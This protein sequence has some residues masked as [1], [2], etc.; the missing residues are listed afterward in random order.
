MI[1]IKKLQISII[2][3]IAASLTVTY[4]KKD[5]TSSQAKSYSDTVKAVNEAIYSTMQQN[6]FWYDSIPVVNPD[7]DINPQT[8]IN[9][10]VNKRDRWSF[11]LTREQYQSDFVTGVY[12]GYGFSYG[13]DPQYNMRIAYVFSSS[14]LY[15]AGVK[16]GWIIKSVNGVNADTSTA[17]TL[18]GGNIDGLKDTFVFVKPGGNDTTLAFAKK[19]VVQNTVLAYDTLHVD[20]E[21]VGYISFLEFELDADSALKSAIAYFLQ[22]NVSDL[23]LDLRYNGGGSLDIAQNLANM[24]AG[25]I[26]NGKTFVNLAFNSKNTGSNVTYKFSSVPVSLTLNRLFVITTSNTASASEV[27]INCLRPYMNVYLIGSATN[28]KPVGEVQFLLPYY[29]YFYPITFA[30]TNA[31][32]YGGYFGGL[33]VNQ[34]APDD[35][36][37]NFGDRNEAC[38]SQALYFITNG[39]F[40]NTKAAGLSKIKIY[41][42]EH[43][44]NHLILKSIYK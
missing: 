2:T 34:T 20:N 12:Y 31:D 35:L 11:I 23:V 36:T 21:V 33:A 29:Y 15:T 7:V 40:N 1:K 25:N 37:H 30:L 39:N 41:Q 5:V 8:F 18:F 4:C 28:G 19:N 3:L 22:N 38:L 43:P 26:A 42:E 14:D 27:I 9:S 16:R 32:N 44:V 10:I 6:Y 13:F 17:G 24:L